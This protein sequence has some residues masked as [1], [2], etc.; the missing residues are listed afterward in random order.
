M[1]L[2]DLRPILSTVA[3]RIA[4]RPTPGVLAAVAFAAAGIVMLGV[5]FLATLAIERRTET[6]VTT[7][8][9]TAAAG[10]ASVSVDGLRVT[11]TGSAPNEAE[12]FRAINVAGSVVDSGR[13]IDA[14][15]AVPAKAVGAPRFSVEMLRN[16]D[17]VQLIG[18]LP[19]DPGDDGISKDALL[20]EVAKFAPDT[21]VSNMLETAAY[22]PPPGWNAALTFGISALHLLPSAKISVDAERVAVIA[23]TD[24]EEQKRSVE[25]ELRKGKP[26]DIALEMNVSAPRPVIAPFTLR[27]VI[28]NQGARFDAC[29]ADTDVARR[30]ILAAGGVAGAPADTPC[31]IGL[32]VPTPRWSEAVEAVISAVVS[33]GGGSVTIS[34]ADIT[35][36]APQGVSQTTLDRVVG[37]LEQ[38]L[39]AV[40]SLAASLGVPTSE[41][42]GPAEF[43]ATLSDA[44]AVEIG[45]RLVDELQREAVMAYAKAAFGSDKV[46]MA[47]RLDPGMPNGWPVRVMAGLQALDQLTA[48]NLVVRPDSVTVRGV[49]GSPQARSQIAQILSRQ[50]GQGQSFQVDVRYDA[51]LD[52]DAA[53]PPAED[54]AARI[55]DILARNK[56]AFAPGSAEIAGPATPT[57]AAIADVLDGCPVM[58]MEIGGHTDA[59][60]SEGG[61]LALSQAR[62]D[63]VL[64]ALQGRRVDVSG[65]RAVGYG[66]TRPIADNGTD[67]G[68][69]ANRRIE[70][71][72]LGS[73]GAAAGQGDAAPDGQGV[74]RPSLAPTEPT[75]RP[76]PRPDQG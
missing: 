51:A 35:L 28:D 34:D 43:L 67:A 72:L 10:W 21:G 37:E 40:F 12:R 49:T 70:F 18:L 31:A 27:F 50:L 22:P 33:L 73:K 58:L 44:G 39:P 69:E 59:Q 62:A 74:N 1:K 47:A 25:A 52:P 75:I 61:N 66:E 15:D 30:R 32:G 55:T 42:Q 11:L 29:S 64:L 46:K 2:P 65:M 68:R 17:S 13:I 26:Q 41:G 24:S 16:N 19:Q 56:I 60:G 23:I 71:T 7:A 4:V 53:P 36:E 48:G 57:I 63:A 9:Q 38:G 3:A 6:A 54:C 14:L 45:G 20:A 8:L 76:K 5:A